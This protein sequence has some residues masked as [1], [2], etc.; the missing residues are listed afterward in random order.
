MKVEINQSKCEEIAK[1]IKNFRV[2][3]KPQA[4][5]KEGEKEKK[6]FY[7]F[8]ATAICHQINWD[9]LLSSLKNIQENQPEKFTPE[10]LSSISNEELHEWL[11]DYSKPW[12]LKI[13]K[14]AEFVRDC[15]ENLIRFFDG[16]VMNLISQSNGFIEGKDGLYNLLSKFK[17]Y[18]EDPL[19]KKSS[20]L[21]RFLN[22]YGLI[23]IKDPEN[24]LVPIDYHVARVNLRNGRI[25]VNDEEL[26]NKLTNGIGVEPKEDIEIRSAVIEAYKIISE[27]VGSKLMF[28]DFDW[29]IGR[30]CCDIDNPC[31]EEN[32]C[33]IKNCTPLSRLEFT[34]KKKCPFDGVCEG[35]H[36][37]EFKK[38]KE[39][40]FE[41][42]FY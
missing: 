11:K 4:Q 22:D 34:C 21:I 19:K 7:F 20:V 9:F 32:S 3:S 5:L 15:S 39:H 8:I 24:Y 25:V 41:T 26:R 17:A 31:C 18:S 42:T 29:C 30:D 35:S 27:I 38:L 16:R 6:A 40:K 33:Q 2:K 10:Y 13:E 12:R 1:I 36:N 37:I 28:T 14:R 23:K